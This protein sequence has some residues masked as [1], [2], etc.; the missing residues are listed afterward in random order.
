M[1]LPKQEL[2][3]PD[4]SPKD[5]DR[6]FALIFAV[7]HERR[8][9]FAMENLREFLPA[10]Y[11]AAPD[12]HALEESLEHDDDSADDADLFHAVNGAAARFSPPSYEIFLL[13][14]TSP[15]D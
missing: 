13:L 1:R 14:G 9:F 4:G 10:A 3:R 7:A 11:A 2:A 8:T 5:V 15:A 6:E 12:P